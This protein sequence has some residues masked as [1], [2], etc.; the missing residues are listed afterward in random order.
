MGLL[1]GKKKKK[2]EEKEKV[3]RERASSVQ[4]RPIGKDRRKKRNIVEMKEPMGIINQHQQD[5]TIRYVRLFD[6]VYGV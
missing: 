2:A 3:K 5:R 6:G 1:V 4:N